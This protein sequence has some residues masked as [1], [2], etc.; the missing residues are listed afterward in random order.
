MIAHIPRTAPPTIPLAADKSA[1]T[2]LTCF[3]NLRGINTPANFQKPHFPLESGGEMGYTHF[4]LA[5]KG[6]MTDYP[7]G[8]LASNRSRCRVWVALWI[9]PWKT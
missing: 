8:W 7:R 4:R 3:R 9:K 6:E 2:G 1:K 5:R